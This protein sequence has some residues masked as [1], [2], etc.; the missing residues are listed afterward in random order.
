MSM[1]QNIIE[2]AIENIKEQIKEIQKYPQ[3]NNAKSMLV[4]ALMYYMSAKKHLLARNREEANRCVRVAI[5][6]TVMAEKK[7]KQKTMVLALS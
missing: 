7:I 4:S 6:L 1:A 5:G 2:M 3:Y